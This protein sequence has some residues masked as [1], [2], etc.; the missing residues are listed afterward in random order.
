MNIEELRERQSLSLHQKIDHSIGVIEQFI[1]KTNGK[2]YIGFSGGKDSTVLLDL[3][4]MV[5][6]D[7][8][9]VFCNTGNEYPDIVKFVRSIDNVD[10]IYPAMK[11][12]EV[13]EKHGFPL[14][15]K[16]SSSI[17]R[18]A[19]HN[20]NGETYKNL[21]ENRDSLFSLPKKWF[22]LL[23]EKYEVSEKCCDML[24]KKP[25]LKY[26]KDTK[27]FPIIG[28]MASESLQR[29]MK[30]LQI[31]TCNQFGLKTISKPLSIWTEKDIWDYIEM[32]HLQ[33][34]DIYHK[35]VKRTGCM[36]CGYG[37]QFKEDNRLQVVYDL[38]PKWYDKFMGY[39]NNGIT[40]K[41]ALRTV[42]RKSGLFLPDE[43]PDLFK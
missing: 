2:C 37:C 27:T 21:I 3:C 28:E 29:E 43:K 12:N 19:R 1:S 38:Y 25:F 16:S 32:K 7:M 4:R 18:K 22:Y 20:P 15:S 30:Y 36:F 9:A 34:A 35:G 41:D 42:L 10:I 23:N 14:V 6:P 5:K 8:K 11:P 26:N 17:I 39:T 33:I 31:G 40:Y 24:K 13:F